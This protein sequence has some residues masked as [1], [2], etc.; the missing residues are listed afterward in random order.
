M[1]HGRPPARKPTVIGGNAPPISPPRAGS[2]PR[3]PLSGVHASILGGGLPWKSWGYGYFGGAYGPIG[4]VFNTHPDGSESVCSG[5]LVAVNVV[6]T[7]AH[8]V[9][10]GATGEWYHNVIFIPSVY[11]YSQ[12]AGRWG[13][14]ALF[15]KS[16]WATPP[17]NRVPGTGGQGYL[18]EDYAFITLYP[19][20]GGQNAG[21]YVGTAGFL[22]DAPL[23]PGI[24]QIGYPANGLWANGCSD[25]YCLPW[26]CWGAIQRYD[27]YAY[28]KWE[29]AMSCLDS[30][31]A[32]GGP[33]LQ[34]R[35]G[36]WYVASVMSQ[37]TVD[38]G[39]PP[40][41]WAGLTAFGPRLDSDT[42]SLFNYA[43]AH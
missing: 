34:S 41:P 3:P 32:S 29:E 20:S 33:W 11:G 7:A 36:A 1:A 5:T 31:G 13:A 10:N 6:L 9:Q 40:G 28:G 8:C 16:R 19:D 38:W 42:G 22:M 25:S 4:R 17:F 35:N 37:M 30:G 21:N 14:R 23:H 39:K 18:P 26:Y 12:P 43:L 2:V 15:T 24:F 27:Q